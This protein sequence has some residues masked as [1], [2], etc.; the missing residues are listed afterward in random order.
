MTARGDVLRESSCVLGGDRLAEEDPAVPAVATPRALEVKGQAELG[1]V[2]PGSERR[3]LW[4]DQAV[5]VPGAVEV[6]AEPARSAVGVGGVATQ[7]VPA[8]FDPGTASFVGVL[9]H[10]LGCR[11]SA[12]MRLKQGI[13]MLVTVDRVRLAP[14]HE[15][16]DHVGSR[17]EV[18]LEERD[19]TLSLLA[20]IAGSGVHGRHFFGG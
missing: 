15:R 6:Q 2:S 16:G 14:G 18:R 7:A 1:G 8:C 19:Q 5:G 3:R 4:V 9:R 12:D 17:E 11:R 13:E 20:A 10:G